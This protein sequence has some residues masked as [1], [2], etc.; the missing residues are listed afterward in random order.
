MT[1]RQITS[2][3]RY[4]LSV[5]RAQEP[6]PT[7]RQVAAAM[8]RHPS[9]IY[10]ELERNSTRHDGAY[11][12]DKAQ[13]YANGRRHR[14]GRRRFSLEELQL[15]EHFIRAEQ[16]SP[17]QT[18]GEVTRWGWLKISARTI[19]RHVRMD[20]RR[21][22]HLH[23]QLRHGRKRRR[24]RYGRPDSRGRLM[25]KPHISQR[26]PAVE[27]RQELGHWE[28]D[29]MM[30]DN[31][32]RHCVLTLVERVSGFVLIGKLETR[33]AACATACAIR[34]IRSHRG[35]FK[36]ITADNG[37]EFHDYDQIERATGVMVYFANPHSSWERG[38]N[39][40]TNGLIRQYLPK[41]RSMAKVTQEDCDAIADK[42]NTRP[43]K[44]HE[45]KSPL[46]R[47]LED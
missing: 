32:S 2:E 16:W 3:E 45:F 13:K 30:G 24:K 23:L 31:P 47:I 7:V 12:P 8:G 21:G 33:T 36:T 20:Q 28:M 35:L 25:G 5:L 9:T 29:T 34:L 17:E 37:T 43:R 46:E 38:T 26:P 19:Y 11:R 27:T 14:S 22:G 44:R 4:T 18:S 15:I 1:Y 41:R 42:L 6:H 10:R 39:E 40:N